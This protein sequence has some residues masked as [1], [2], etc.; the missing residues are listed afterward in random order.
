MELD[1][2]IPGTTPRLPN[3]RIIPSAPGIRLPTVIALFGA[4]GAGKT[5]VLNVVNHTLRFALYSHEHHAPSV[6][7]PFL[8]E[9][10]LARPT[11]IE[12]SFAA[13]HF[14]DTDDD[15]VSLYRYELELARSPT[16]PLSTRVAYEALLEFPR[17]RRR[18]IFERRE[19]GPVYIAPKAG[20]TSQDRAVKATRPEA[21]LVATLAAS[22]VPMFVC[23]RD[24]L[25]KIYC[26]PESRRPDTQTT[27][28]NYARQTALVPA[29]SKQ[30]QRIDVGIESM[31]VAELA[32]DRR[33]L[34]FAHRGLSGPLMMPHE[35]AGT[36][37]FVS[38]FPFLNYA[39]SDGL[40]VLLDALDAEFHADLAAE[41]I[42]WFQSLETNP[43]GAQLI[44]TLHN[45]ALLESLEKEEVVMVKKSREGVT[46]AYGLWQVQGLRRSANLYRE[47]RSGDLG[48]LPVIG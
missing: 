3:F 2:R 10:G 8:S 43:G 41:I 22:F 46:S 45:L 4:N 15:R 35:S 40:V 48:G 16:H 23:I 47:Y 26:P 31:K 28:N 5:T 17:R 19:Q 11:R 37:N 24:N 39:L 6:L 42:H 1:F 44:C 21:S 12:I 33:E 25:S 13:S 7:H 20:I 32:G 38:H 34:I 14:L 18:R 30:L 9:S 29:V 27:T 36:R